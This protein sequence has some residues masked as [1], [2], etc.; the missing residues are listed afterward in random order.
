MNRHLLAKLHLRCF[1][2]VNTR[3]TVAQVEKKE[4]RESVKSE[5]E[6]DAD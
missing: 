6:S 1:L 5:E 3:T 2:H 4:K